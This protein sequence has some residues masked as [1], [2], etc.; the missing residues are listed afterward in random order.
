MLGAMRAVATIA[1][2]WWAQLLPDRNVLACIP[3][4]GVPEV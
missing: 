1:G 4:R 3:A 2:A